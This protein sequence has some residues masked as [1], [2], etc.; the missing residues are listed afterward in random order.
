M[1]EDASAHADDH[2]VGPLPTTRRATA[3]GSS[4]DELA[5]PLFGTWRSPVA[6]L[7]GGQGVAGSNP[8]VPTFGP[9]SRSGSGPSLCVPD[10]N[11]RER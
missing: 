2:I 5:F 8:A 7:T 11:R 6:H 1:G 3:T 9:E 10:E 4:A